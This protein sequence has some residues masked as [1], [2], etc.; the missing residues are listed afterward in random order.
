VSID[1]RE[2]RLLWEHEAIRH[3]NF[4]AGNQGDG[5][6]YGLVPID[7]AGQKKPYAYDRDDEE[8]DED[9]DD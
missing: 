7:L 2:L 8:T 1:P 5:S 3:K 9:E 4:T 6:V